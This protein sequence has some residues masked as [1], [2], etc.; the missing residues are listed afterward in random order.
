MNGQNYDTY[1][2]VMSVTE[3][4][5]FLGISRGYVYRLM[6]EKKLYGIRIGKGY[7]IPKSSVI[8]L[9]EGED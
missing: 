6:Q 5:I 4:S 1:G 2:D 8:A 7:T 9:V 3:V